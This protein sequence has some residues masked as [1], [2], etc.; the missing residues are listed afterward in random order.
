MSDPYEKASDAGEAA[1]RRRESKLEDLRSLIERI[2]DDAQANGA[3]DN[4]PGQGKPLALDE[5]NPFASDRELAYKLLKDNDYT[6]P[7]IAN[8]NA[9]LEKIAA[10]RLGLGRTWRQYEAR[11]QSAPDEA[12]GAALRTK[13]RARYEA[14]LAETAVLNLEIADVNL[15]VPVS[16]LEILKLSL[17]RELAMVGG[18]AD[19]DDS[20]VQ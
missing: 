14:L 11:F 5:K 8:R 2:I 6:L 12:H 7:W 10:F 3:F 13:W 19:L 9:M 20:A 18:R 15:Q 4:L 16:R 17:E 1:R